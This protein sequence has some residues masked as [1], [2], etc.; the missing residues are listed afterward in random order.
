MQD[1]YAQPLDRNMGLETYLFQIELSK[2]VDESDVVELFKKI[3]MTCLPTSEKNK[4]LDDYRSYYFEERTQ[5][6][7]L[8]ANMIFSPSEENSNEFSLRFSILSPKTIIDRTFDLLSKL[9]SLTPIKVY[10]TEIQNHIY[11]QLRKEGVLDQNFEGIEGSDK[12]K[13]IQHQCYI[14]IDAIVF[15]KND[16][17]I[18]KRRLVLS[19]EKGEIIESGSKTIDAIQKKGLADKFLS[20]FKNE[21]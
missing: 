21:V 18:Q 17:S 6:G 8:E 9:N 20:W 10:D 16:L 4:P 5:N 19:N 15:S 14:P 1:R 11:R 12:E 3:G 7:L 2:P 13:E